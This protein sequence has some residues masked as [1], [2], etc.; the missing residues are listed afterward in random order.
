MSSA[1]DLTIGNV[2]LALGETEFF[3]ATAVVEDVDVVVD[4]NNHQYP[5]INADLARLAV[6]EVI[7]DPNVEELHGA[8]TFKLASADVT[9]CSTSSARSPGSVVNIS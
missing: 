3:V 7:E 5:S 9:S 8:T 6:D 1:F 4:S 2:D